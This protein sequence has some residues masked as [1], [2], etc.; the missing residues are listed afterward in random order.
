MF[1]IPFSSFVTGYDSIFRFFSIFLILFSYFRI[2]FYIVEISI[3]NSFID[4]IFIFSSVA[5]ISFSN[6]S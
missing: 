1:I 3:T 5:S 2:I 6:S 4:F